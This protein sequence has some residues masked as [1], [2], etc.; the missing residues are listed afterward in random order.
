MIGALAAVGL[1]ATGND[2]RVVYLASSGDDLLDTSGPLTVEAI[3]SRGIDEVRDLAT[4]AS[5]TTGV[6]TIQK[7]LRPNWR[8][9]R[10]VLFVSRVG[11]Q[12]Y[13]WEKVA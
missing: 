6:V 12:E 11:E 10:V 5:I 3:L 7:K 2:G 4:G 1:M 13:A 8:D 9:G